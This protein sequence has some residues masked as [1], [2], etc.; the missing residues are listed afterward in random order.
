M[1]VLFWDIDGTLLTTAKGGM[2][3]W[4]DGVKEITAEDGKVTFQYDIDKNQDI[5]GNLKGHLLLM[6]GDVD[7]N[8]H[9]S[10]TYRVMDALIRAN[11][12][13]DFIMLPGQPHSYGPMGDYVYWRR[14]DYFSKWLL[15]VEN[16]NTEMLELQREIASKK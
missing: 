15:G 8:V 2:F 13:F 16:T 1:T 12:R 7:N 14:I 4:D 11:K 9:P 10:N 5:A 6:T 3:A